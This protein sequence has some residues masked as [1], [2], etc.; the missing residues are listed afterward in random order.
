MRSALN[1]VMKIEQSQQAASAGAAAHRF[2]L[3][4]VSVF[5]DKNDVAS[6][7]SAHEVISLQQ[8]DSAIGHEACA[9]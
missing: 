7:G 4:A 9:M 3:S 1:T 5:G 2:G 8:N 6:R